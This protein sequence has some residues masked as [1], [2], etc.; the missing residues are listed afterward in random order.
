VRPFCEARGLEYTE[1]GWWTSYR[2]VAAALSGL[3]RSAG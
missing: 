1:V 2:M 3:R